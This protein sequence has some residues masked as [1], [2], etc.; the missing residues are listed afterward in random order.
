L[1]RSGVSLS[2]GIKGEPMGEAQ[3]KGPGGGRRERNTGVSGMGA[4]PSKFPQ[5]VLGLLSQ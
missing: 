3:G 2:V 4:Q 5:G 1:A